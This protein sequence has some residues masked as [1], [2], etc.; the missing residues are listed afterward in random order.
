MAASK[1]RNESPFDAAS[2]VL[3]GEEDD[4]ENNDDEND[5]EIDEDSNGKDRE[6]LG[7]CDEKI[8]FKRAI[9]TTAIQPGLGMRS[10]QSFSKPP[11]HQTS[12]FIPT[13]H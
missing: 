11:P 1:L 6:T 13:P 9:Q 10:C 8:Q 5:E 4:D 12:P 3:G 2:S 7:N